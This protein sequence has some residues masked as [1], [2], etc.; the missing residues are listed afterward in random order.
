MNFGNIYWERQGSEHTC[1]IHTLNSLL[2]G[3]IFTRDLFH[4]YAKRLLDMQISLSP[5]LNEVNCR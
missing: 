5:E 3:P 2:Q 4:T 1:G